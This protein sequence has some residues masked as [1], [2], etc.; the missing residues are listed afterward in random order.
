MQLIEYQ[1]LLRTDRRHR[2]IQRGILP[3]RCYTHGTITHHVRSRLYLSRVTISRRE[4]RV[5]ATQVSR[6][7]LWSLDKRDAWHDMVRRPL[8]PLLSKECQRTL[9]GTPA[10]GAHIQCR[11]LYMDRRTH[12]L[13]SL[14]AIRHQ[15]MLVRLHHARWRDNTISDRRDIHSR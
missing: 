8:S 2:Y 9:H 3:R 4:C 5:M 6:D 12:S 1:Y 14:R 15:R 7:A 10:L 11:S 13:W